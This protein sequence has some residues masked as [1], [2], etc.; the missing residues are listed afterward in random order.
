MRLTKTRIRLNRFTWIGCFGCQVSPLSFIHPD[1]HDTGLPEH[2]TLFKLIMSA[3]FNH[4]LQPS[5]PTVDVVVTVAD[6]GYGQNVF[7]LDGDFVTEFDLIEGV[8]Y[9]FDQSDASN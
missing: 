8:T 1:E 7:K 3:V 5:G 2:K 6:D 9:V 4:S